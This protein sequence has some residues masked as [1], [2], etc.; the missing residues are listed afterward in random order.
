MLRE[1]MPLAADKK[2][3]S[4]VL[5]AAGNVRTFLSLMFVSKYIDDPDASAAASRSAMQLALP[6]ADAKPGLTGAEVRNTLLRMLDKLTGEDSQYERIDIQTYLENL[7]Y[8]KGYESIFNG[9]DLTGWQGLV[10][11]PIVRS[12]MTKEVLAK[13]QKEANAKVSNNWSVKDGYIVFQGDGANLCT[14][15]KYGDFEMLVD[16]KISKNGFSKV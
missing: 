16:W 12:K 5:R 3:K 1:I 10:E 15:R 13:K 7:P 14:I 8:T 11:N 6:T 2:E 4:M 9:K